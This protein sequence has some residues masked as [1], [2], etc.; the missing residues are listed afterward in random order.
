M[1]CRH[2][3]P[4]RILLYSQMTGYGLNLQ[5]STDQ[6]TTKIQCFEQVETRSR[7]NCLVLS[8]HDRPFKK[9][10]KRKHA[11]HHFFISDVVNATQRSH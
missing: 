5:K 1:S 9:R 3:I 7:H 8:W 6:A 11:S 2:S 4:Q 10:I